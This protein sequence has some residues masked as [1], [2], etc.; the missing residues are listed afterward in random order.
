MRF[1]HPLIYSPLVVCFFHTGIDTVFYAIPEMQRGNYEYIIHHAL[2]IWVTVALA[3]SKSPELL[4]LVPDVLLCELSTIFFAIGWIMRST[5]Y[6]SSPLIKGLEIVFAITFFATRVVNMPIGVIKSW[7]VSE[8]IGPA[9]FT[10][11]PIVLMQWYWMYKIAMAAIVGKPDK[12]PSA[13][14]K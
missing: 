12:K 2:A 7:H 4:R 1:D 6:R 5:S 8:E 10:L 11:I 3:D 14:T 9:R 13:A